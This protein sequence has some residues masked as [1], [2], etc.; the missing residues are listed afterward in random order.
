MLRWGGSLA[1]RRQRWRE[2]A[3]IRVCG[4][5]SMWL[6]VLCVLAAAVESIDLDLSNIVAH[7]ATE[8]KR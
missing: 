3:G 5:M 6:A 1:R 2:I 4:G 7:P 8:R